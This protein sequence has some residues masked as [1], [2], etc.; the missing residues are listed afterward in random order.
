MPMRR[1]HQVADFLSD[2]ARKTWMAEERAVSPVE[3]CPGI[4][5]SQ[6]PKSCPLENTAPSPTA[7]AILTGHDFDL[8][9]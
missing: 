2:P 3:I 1:L 7:A 9:R 6:A 8:A 4:S 5:P